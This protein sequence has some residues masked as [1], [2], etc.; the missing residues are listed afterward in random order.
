MPTEKQIKNFREEGQY[1]R[2]TKEYRRWRQKNPSLFVKGSFRAVPLDHTRYKGKK[3]GK[4]I[5]GRLKSTKKWMIQSI[6]E[7][8]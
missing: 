4:A 2:V 5:V 1:P 3:K 7:E 6:L 8:K